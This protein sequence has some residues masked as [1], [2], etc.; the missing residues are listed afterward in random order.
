MNDIVE[1][2]S[3]DS[4]SKKIK[5]IV[6]LSTNIKYNLNLNLL[7]DKLSIILSEV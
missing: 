1:K 3:I 5:I 7:I 6:D 4:I 2:N